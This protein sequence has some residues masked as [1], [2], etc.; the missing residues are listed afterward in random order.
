MFVNNLR[1]IW[2]INDSL[3]HVLH[4]DPTPPPF[5]TSCMVMTRGLL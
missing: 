1:P 5:Q 4:E 2:Q 3:L